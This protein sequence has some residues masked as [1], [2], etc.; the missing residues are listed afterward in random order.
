MVKFTVICASILLLSCSI[1]VPRSIRN[2]FE[3]S[4][5]KDT[6]IDSLININGY[7]SVNVKWE[8]YYRGEYVGTRESIRKFMFFANGSFFDDVHYSEEG[9]SII[10]YQ[11]CGNFKIQ[12]D[13]IKAH[14]INHPSLMAPW[15]AWETWY[16]VINK[17]EIAVIKSFPIHPMTDSDW[18][19][20]DEYESRRERS[21]GFF[22][23][24]SNMPYFDCWLKQEKWFWCSEEKYKKY[25][26]NKKQ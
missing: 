3:C 18:K 5:S 9:D 11:F 21:I 19:L 1:N 13:T 15:A 8:E 17:N 16:K 26:Q 12:G 24:V 6:G 25:Q 20:F 23:P 4:N 22:T 10:G 2:K 14:G 7:Y